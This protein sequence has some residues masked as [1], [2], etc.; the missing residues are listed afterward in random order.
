MDPLHLKAGADLR[1][2]A[3]S[4]EDDFYC[5]HSCDWLHIASS[6]TKKIWQSKP[7][8]KYEGLQDTK[9]IEQ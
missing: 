9:P 6:I 4:T 5:E 3:Q 2:G 7:R 1:F 8:K